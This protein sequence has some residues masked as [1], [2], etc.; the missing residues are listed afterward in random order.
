MLR[1]CP[2]AI[3][4][5][6]CLAVCSSVEAQTNPPDL[7]SSF[8][9]DPKRATI[10]SQAAPTRPVP[11]AAIRQRPDQAFHPIAVSEQ[12]IPLSRPSGSPNLAISNT[13]TA[14]LAI[15]GKALALVLGLFL[16]GIWIARTTRSSW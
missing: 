10:P 9:A 8:V 14:N 3:F 13:A 15:V 12:A 5:A 2:T 6:V 1:K 4:A 11:S 16:G 7:A